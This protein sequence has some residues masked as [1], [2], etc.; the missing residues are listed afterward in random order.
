MN[1]LLAGFDEHGDGVL[2]SS[3]SI[4]NETKKYAFQKTAGQILDER[5]LRQRVFLSEVWMADGA[6]NTPPAQSD[7]RK[8]GVMV[9][10]SDGVNVL[11]GIMGIE[12]DWETGQPAVMNP[13]FSEGDVRTMHPAMAAALGLAITVPDDV[14]TLTDAEASE[15]TD[16]CVASIDAQINLIITYPDRDAVAKSDQIMAITPQQ[17]ATLRVLDWLVPAEREMT[18]LETEPGNACIVLLATTIRSIADVLRVQGFDDEV[19]RIRDALKRS[20]AAA[21]SN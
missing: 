3:N 19:R 11:T 16:E 13:E 9:V 20:D 6:G 10:A 14:P 17:P 12:R 4:T 2:L 21:Q 1:A 5:G 18:T 8:E 15:V 7:S